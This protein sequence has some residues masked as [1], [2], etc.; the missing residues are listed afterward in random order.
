METM[1]IGRMASLAGVNIDTVRYYER[2]GLLPR[3][4]RRPSGYREYGLDDVAR[5]K[6][7]RR[8]KGLGFSLEEIGELLSLSADRQND[9]QGVKRKAEAR[10]R[11]VEVKIAELQRVRRALKRLIDACPGQ[12]ELQGCPI[13]AALDD[14]GRAREQGAE[15]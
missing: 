15:S 7:I 6:F 8:A 2:N 4:R 13:L 3:A 5:L 10:L 14:D 11:H 12:G 9:M 1:T